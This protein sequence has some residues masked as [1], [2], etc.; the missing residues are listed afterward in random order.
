MALAVALL[1]YTDEPDYGDWSQMDLWEEVVY[2]ASTCR[3]LRAIT[4]HARRRAAKSWAEAADVAISR[5]C[6]YLSAIRPSDHL[7]GPASVMLYRLAQTE[8]LQEDEDAIQYVTKLLPV[9]ARERD[10]LGAIPVRG[11]PGLLMS[12]ALRA[13]QNH[14]KW[15]D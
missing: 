12:M 7:Y 15:R 14:L 8:S 13:L 3:E 5:T 6:I 9:L 4:E 11:C 2:L 1:T 10:M